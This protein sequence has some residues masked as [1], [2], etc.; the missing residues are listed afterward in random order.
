MQIGITLN[1]RNKP[2]SYQRACAKLVYLRNEHCWMKRANKAIRKVM[3]QS[4]DTVDRTLMLIDILGIDR[5]TASCL[6][7]PNPDGTMGYPPYI[8]RDY[9]DRIRRYQQAIDEFAAN[10]PK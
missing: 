5:W 3:R 4:D 6:L 10:H 8:L 9:R 2:L 1:K 7:E